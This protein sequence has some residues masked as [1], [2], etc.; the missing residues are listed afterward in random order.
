MMD[1]LAKLVLSNHRV[2]KH[3]CETVLGIEIEI[4][5]V[6]L[7]P[8]RY[9]KFQKQEAEDTSNKTAETEIDVL[10]KLTNGTE[11]LIEIQRAGQK[12]FK[13][14]AVFYS[15]KN[16]VDQFPTILSEHKTHVA[17][18]YLRPV[19]S[20]CIMEHSVFPDIKSPK[21]EFDIFSREHNKPLLSEDGI[22]LKRYIFIQ[23]DQ[24]DPNME[25]NRL[26]HWLQ[27][28]K[29]KEISKKA[30]AEILEADSMIDEKTWN[31][32]YRTMIEWEI[33]YEQDE[34]AKLEE[35]E[36]RGRAKGIAE[37]EAEAKERAEAILLANISRMILK[38]L[39]DDEISEMLDT[40]L[41]KVA[42]TRNELTPSGV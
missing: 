39:R 9:T 31:K 29:N 23:L 6:I 11:I 14:R 17:Y 38:G 18:K 35:A 28:W 15:D 34:L 3:F 4:Q 41:Q 2:A 30:D 20:I 27:Y 24:Y 16:F 37:A 7:S 10:A 22:P 21:I 5:Q 32:E 25:E 26:K 8:S 19:Y 42:Q 1:E 13:E 36:D 33:R 12:Y 40:P